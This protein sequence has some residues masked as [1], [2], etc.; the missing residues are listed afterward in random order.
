MTGAVAWV[1]GLSGSGKSTL[2]RRL[3][4]RLRARG[5]AAALLDGDAVR[6]AL[7][8]APGY[9]P[10]ARAAFYETL[11]NLAL[12]LAREGLAVVVAAT[13]HRREF[14]DRSLAGEL[15]PEYPETDV[16]RY[17][18]ERISYRFDPEKRRALALYLD[19]AGQ[20]AALDSRLTSGPA[21]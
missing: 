14:R 12:A 7:V 6:A 4:D 9:D 10:A 3:R 19:Y 15:A 5:I 13:A 1:T 2:A 18:T 16:R 20:V 21:V 8:P 17:L 11:G